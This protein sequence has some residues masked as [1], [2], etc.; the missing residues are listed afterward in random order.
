MW[1]STLDENLPP[2]PD[3][4]AVP[5]TAEPR[6][7]LSADESSRLTRASFKTA[8]PRG[9]R[10]APA[11]ASLPL[12]MRWID[13]APAGEQFGDLL[14]YGCGT[15]ADVTYYRN[16]GLDAEGYDPHPPFGYADLPRRQF[17]VVTLMFVLNVLPTAPE[18]REV[19]RRAASFLAPAGLLVVATRSTSAIRAAAHKGNRRASNDGFISD[20][21]RS[22]FQHGMD[23]QEI[24]GLGAT[25]GLRPAEALPRVP[26]ASLAAFSNDALRST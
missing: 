21:R 11:D 4:R 20:E 5:A 14:D 10:S 3:P 23:D 12:I 7:E 22:T 1:C 18:R 15:G 6:L 26:R 17:R 9:K 24:R 25:V 8:I 19:L 13:L 16:Q 2:T